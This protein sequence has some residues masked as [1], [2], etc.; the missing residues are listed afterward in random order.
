MKYILPFF[1]LVFLSACSHKEERT[2][3]IVNLK[4]ST[5]KIEK[6][7]ENCLDD[8]F[9]C[10]YKKA[11]DGDI[12]SQEKVAN[13]YIEKKEYKKAEPWL[14]KLSQKD[15]I[16]AIKKL[17]F[18][19]DK[20][21]GDISEDKSKAFIFF[22]DGANL[23]DLNSQ[24]HVGYYYKKGWGVK[25]DYLNAMRWFKKASNLGHTAAM[26]EVAY[27]YVK[28]LGYEQDY[29]NAVKWFE[30]AAKKDDKYSM[31]WIAYLYE[32]GMGLPQDYSK[33]IYWYKSSG[34]D[35]SKRKLKI[36]NEKGIIE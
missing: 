8:D 11:L 20:G 34:T 29:S 7:N 15:N 19:Y 27:L 31:S 4:Q 16:K 21:I 1:L 36:L 28:G 30:K 13:Y 10:N 9:T 3:D 2:K 33:A 17:A 12:L 14:I 35:Y 5:V 32:T 25:Q 23:E 22:K 26:R 18:Y 6:L 24:Y